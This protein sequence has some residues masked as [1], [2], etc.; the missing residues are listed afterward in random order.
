MPVQHKDQFLKALRLLGWVATQIH[1]ANNNCNTCL[2]QVT[3]K[4]LSE[5][6]KLHVQLHL[7]HKTMDKPILDVYK[8]ALLLK[9]YG[10]CEVRASAVSA[11]FG[12]VTGPREMMDG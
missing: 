4:D 7:L 1:Q 12:H 3:L 11:N 9:R 5:N 8:T 2:S 10:K 6:S